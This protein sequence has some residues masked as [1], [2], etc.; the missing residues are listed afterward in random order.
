[1]NKI[2]IL[3]NVVIKKDPSPIKRLGQDQLKNQWYLE[4]PSKVF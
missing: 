3:K 1:M 2:H 4:L